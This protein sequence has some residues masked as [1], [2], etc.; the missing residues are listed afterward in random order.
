[1]TSLAVALSCHLPYHHEETS[2]KARTKE[3]FKITKEE[4]TI[5]LP[6]NILCHTK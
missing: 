2:M 6:E 5:V 4:K 1:L 3:L